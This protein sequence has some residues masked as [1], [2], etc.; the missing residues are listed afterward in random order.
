MK[1]Y[2]ACDLLLRGRSKCSL[3]VITM[4]NVTVKNRGVITIWNQDVA[5]L[6]NAGLM[7]EIV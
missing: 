4:E 6:L 1:H 7:L 5:K 2:Y 3:I